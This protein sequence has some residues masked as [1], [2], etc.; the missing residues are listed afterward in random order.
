M[1]TDDLLSRHLQQW[2]GA[3]PP[4]DVGV[5]VVGCASRSNPGWDGRVHDVIGVAT[6][7][8]AVLSVPL[9]V[10]DRLG[11]VVRGDDLDA[12][13]ARLNVSMPEIVGR[14]GALAGGVFRWSTAPTLSAD[15]GEWVPTDDGRVPP[16][17]MPFNGD[18]LI[19]WDDEGVCGAGVGR[20]MHDDFGHELS[21][22]TEER[23]RRRGIGRALVETAARRVLADGRIPTYLHHP[24]NHASAQL[25]EAAGFPDRGWRVLFFG[26][27]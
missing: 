14:V 2:L 25:A 17:L 8:A 12:D 20:K 15:F 24:E 16:W 5:T 9:A 21:V 6:P 1:P 22:V 10:A 3:W 13:L 7:A 18:V 19:A 11:D 26:T 23:L 27:R 4:R